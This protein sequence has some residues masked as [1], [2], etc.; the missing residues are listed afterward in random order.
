MNAKSIDGSKTNFSLSSLELFLIIF[1]FFSSQ[2]FLFTEYF[3]II[4]IFS[5]VCY[6]IFFKNLNLRIFFL[7]ISLFLYDSN[8]IDLPYIKYIIYM[9]IALE[10]FF[11]LKFKNFKLIFIFL[12]FSFY[13]LFSIISSFYNPF[14][15]SNFIIFS[16]LFFILIIIFAVS[17]IKDITYEPDLFNTFLIFYIIGEIINILFFSNNYVVEGY[18]S[19]NGS[20]IFIIFP[21]FYLYFCNKKILSFLFFF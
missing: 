1:G 4:N 2:R 13:F 19:N 17:D 15:I 16:I 6:F 8:H 9:I 12:I 5:F 11:K 7:I 10:I 14:D 3:F 18:L 20:K 21:F